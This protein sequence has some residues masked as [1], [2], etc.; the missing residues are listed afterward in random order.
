MLGALGPTY[1]TLN[2]EGGPNQSALQYTGR[3]LSLLTHVPCGL[4]DF[5]V[6]LA[7]VGSI[8]LVGQQ[9]CVKDMLTSRPFAAIPNW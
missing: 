2:N 9:K 3:T 4:D 1:L 7:M 6:V 8:D 5:A